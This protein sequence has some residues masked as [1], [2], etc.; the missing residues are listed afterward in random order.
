[1]EVAASGKMAL[2][3]IQMSVT[4]HLFRS[5]PFITKRIKAHVFPLSCLVVVAQIKLKTSTILT[6]S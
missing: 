5:G 1:M 4:R 3:L 6:G 2:S